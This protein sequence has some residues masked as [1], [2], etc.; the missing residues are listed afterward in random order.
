[1]LCVDDKLNRGVVYRHLCF[2]CG[3]TGEYWILDFQPRLDKIHCSCGFEHFIEEIVLQGTPILVGTQNYFDRN[4]IDFET[5]DS[6]YTVE[7]Y[8]GHGNRRLYS[9]GSIVE[10]VDRDNIFYSSSSREEKEK[11]TSK[12]VL[13]DFL[14][15]DDVDHNSIKKVENVQEN[16]NRINIKQIIKHKLILFIIR[17]IPSEMVF[18]R[19]IN[20]IFIERKQELEVDE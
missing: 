16:I 1:M 9:F 8:G 19:L 18:D 6:T 20:I 4:A 5:I 12:F 3:T 7:S 10:K 14:A 2:S 17:F 11:M 15:E 13:S